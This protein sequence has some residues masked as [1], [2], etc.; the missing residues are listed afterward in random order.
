MIGCILTFEIT[1]KLVRDF[2]SSKLDFYI[3][4]PVRTYLNGCVNIA[5]S[6]LPGRPVFIESKYF[7]SFFKI[8]K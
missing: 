2:V 7:L 3:M 5:A 4:K 6:D 8:L 1:E